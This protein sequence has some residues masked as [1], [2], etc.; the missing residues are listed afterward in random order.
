MHMN[1]RYSRQILLRIIQGEGQEIL[2]RSNVV[3]V[4]CGALGTTIEMIESHPIP[5]EVQTLE[6]IV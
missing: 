5:P 4:G 6:L 1:D 2:S 3:V